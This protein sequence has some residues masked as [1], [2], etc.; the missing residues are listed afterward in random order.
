MKKLFTLLATVVM[1]TIVAFIGYTAG[2]DPLYTAAAFTAVAILFRDRL[3]VAGAALL[4][5]VPRGWEN[6]PG[7]NTGRVITRGWQDAIPYAA[8]ITLAPNRLNIEYFKIAQLTGALTLNITTTG[9][10]DFDEVH[11]FF[12]TD[13]TQRIVTLGTGFSSSGTITIPISNGASV[14]GI[15]DKTLDKVLIYAREIT[16]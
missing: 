10:A 1:I 6:R 14:R 16:P 9:L 7:D 4:T 11:I 8:A 2:I 12:R 5:P 15:Y 13:A 3:Y